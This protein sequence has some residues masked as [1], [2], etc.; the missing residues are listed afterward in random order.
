M[1][2]E[3]IP[4]SGSRWEPADGDATPT[5]PLDD[6]T[7]AAPPT[8]DTAVIAEHGVVSADEDQPPRAGR[9]RRRRALR[10]SR[11]RSALAA[12]GVGLVLAGGLGGFAIGHAVADRAATEVSENGDGTDGPTGDHHGGRPD[13]DHDGDAPGMPPGDDGSDDGGTA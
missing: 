13:F 4:T 2:D 1:S 5:R 7:P 8:D 3:D 12:A 11:G 9:L 10:L 6:G